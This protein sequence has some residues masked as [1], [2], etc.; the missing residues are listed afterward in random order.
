MTT[1][2]FEVP[3]GELTF[4]P[5]TMLIDLKKLVILIQLTI[6]SYIILSNS[7]LLPPKLKPG[8]EVI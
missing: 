7:F 5:S 6:I 1:H 8:E 3:F 4:V 2:I